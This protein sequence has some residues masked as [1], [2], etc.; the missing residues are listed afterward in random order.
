MIRQ[1]VNSHDSK[2][3]EPE[4]TEGRL[5]SE[6]MRISQINNVKKYNE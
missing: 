1:V 6:G 2:P 3:G 4:D 5:E